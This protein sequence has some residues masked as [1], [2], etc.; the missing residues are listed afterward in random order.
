[1]KKEYKK[2]ELLIENFILSDYVASCGIVIAFSA[3]KC[4]V[5][6]GMT[7]LNLWHKGL[8]NSTWECE[9]DIAAND[10][11]GICYHG[12]SDSIRAFTS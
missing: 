12:Q 10:G 4:S 11:L 9:A 8:F 6:D 2:P 3:A 7:D 5:P 1:M